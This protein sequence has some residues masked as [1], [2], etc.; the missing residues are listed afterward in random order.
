MPICEPA[1]MLQANSQAYTLVELKSWW[2]R[3][4]DSPHSLEQEKE[5]SD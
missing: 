3:S 1:D 2:C 5:A 4:R